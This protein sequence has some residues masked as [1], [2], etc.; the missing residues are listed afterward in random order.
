MDSLEVTA[1]VREYQKLVGGFI[2]KVYQIDA[3]RFLFK[4]H[5]SGEGRKNLVFDLGKGLYLTERDVETPMTPSH[6]IML[7]RKYLSNARIHDI[8]QHEFDRVV[9][10][11]LQGRQELKL[12][13]EIFGKGNLI[14]VGPEHI[15]LPLRSEKWKHRK[16]KEGETYLYPPSRKEPFK[17]TLDEIEDI[18]DSS[19]TD[20]VRTLAVMLNIGGKYA[21]ELCA[22][23]DIDKNTV[24][25]SGLSSKVADAI[26]GL[27]KQ[28]LEDELSAQMILRDGEVEDAVPFPL[29]IY[30]HLESEP[31]SSFQ[32]ALDTAFN[33]DEEIKEGKK[34]P[35]KQERKLKRQEDSV[36]HMA[37]QVTDSIASAELIYQNY[38]P[39]NEILSRI[40]Q[41]RDEGNREEV[42]A[43]L[44]KSEYVVELNDM[45]EYVVVKLKGIVDDE[46]IEQNIRLD[47]RKDV[48]ENAQKYYQASKKLRK[49]IEGAKKAIEDTKKEIERGIKRQEKSV[50]KKPTSRFWFD[51]YKWFVS[52]DGNLV[53]AGKDTKTNEEVVKK[54]LESKDIYVHAEAGGAPSVVVKSDG[55]EISDRTLEEACQ[56]AVI[57][58]KEWKRGISSGIAYWVYPDQ[59]S[60]TAEA[61]ES[62]PTGAFVVRGK[63][64]FIKDLPLKASIG[65]INY[66]DKRKISVAPSKA[67]GKLE[68]NISFVSGNETSNE[69]AKRMSDRFNVPVTEIQRILPPGGVKEL[70]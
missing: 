50:E 44:R 45:D 21:E 51:R 34:P 19:D 7:L 11:E 32:E 17:L 52:T 28:V 59:V 63:R 62:L 9:V 38:N 54:Y 41:A 70:E 3:Q 20:L 39:C 46:E 12:V 6:Y 13:F 64:N 57:H 65:E 27:K 68:N 48:N 53:I 61:G 14:L 15:I 58:S 22:R 10:F 69:F 60:K 1:A 37:G 66:N 55:A 31:R 18:L 43:A 5:I 49:K 25:F 24:E 16:L 47:F 42:F 40:L 2:Q 33:Q 67:S 36:E 35:T 23:M 56:F 29:M 30:E 26:D 4:I 8:Q